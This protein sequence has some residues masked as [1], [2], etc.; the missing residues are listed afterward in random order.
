MRFFGAGRLYF[1]NDILP[2]V[3]VPLIIFLSK[4][5]IS[6]IYVNIT[7]VYV[8]ES[9]LAEPTQLQRWNY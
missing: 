6:F 3:M 7:Y 9:K 4:T 1:N 5:R 8:T 2:C